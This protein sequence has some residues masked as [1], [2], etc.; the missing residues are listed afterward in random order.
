MQL[1]SPILILLLYLL[2]S[3]DPGICELVKDTVFCELVFELV[4]VSDGIRLVS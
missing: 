1:F 4:S 2:V 3:K